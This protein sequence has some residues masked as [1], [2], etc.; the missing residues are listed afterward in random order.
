VLDEYADIMVFRPGV[1]LNTIGTEACD[2]AADA[3]E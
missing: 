3:I 2:I 1:P